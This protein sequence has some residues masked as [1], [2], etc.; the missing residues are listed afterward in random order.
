LSRAK[1]VDAQL[2]GASE[3][4]GIKYQRE[5]ANL[6][7]LEIQLVTNWFGVPENGRYGSCAQWQITGRA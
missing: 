3:H 4:F 1:N 7:I 2:L 6:W 5:M